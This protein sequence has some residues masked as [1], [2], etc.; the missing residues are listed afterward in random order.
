MTKLRLVWRRPLFAALAAV[1]AGSVGPAAWADDQTIQTTAADDS[2][3]K[4]AKG[5]HRILTA[6]T[7]AA[8][9]RPRDRFH[10]SGQS[11]GGSAN[12]GPTQYPG[13]L[14]YLGGALVDHAQSHAIYLVNKAINCTTPN[15]F[16]NP[17]AFLQDLG[18]SDFIHIT[19]Q[20]VGRHD[21]NRYTVG[22][23][24]FVSRNLSGLTDQDIASVVHA[25]ASQTHLTGYNH[26]YHVFLPPGTDE[27]SDATFTQ[28][29]SPDKPNSFVYC[30]FHGFVDFQDIGHVLLTLE[31]YQNV[32]GCSGPPGTPNGQLVDS[33]ASTLSHELF[34]TITD[35]DI[36]AWI[37]VFSLPL[38][39]EE[40]G[41]VCDFLVFFPNGAIYFDAPVFR[42][43]DKN[44]GV[45]TEY[46]NAAHAC[47]SS[48]M[49]QT[50]P[51]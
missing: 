17:E 23:N 42:I 31:P 26:I 13:D 32:A 1:L 39:G 25:V 18:E 5:S 12:G 14:T 16:G 7:P 24:K 40:I 49:A 3:A 37:N 33:T 36:N 41:D 46:N 43:G 22:S 29:Y 8:A 15:C 19:D 35:P 47:T 34:E 51:E 21:D 38:N 30:A 11:G 50:R 9:A 48:P 6:L 28:C 27:C 10:P 45:Q 4:A 44:Y 20:Y 2:A